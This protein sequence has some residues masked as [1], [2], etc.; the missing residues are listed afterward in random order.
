VQD[1][2]LVNVGKIKESSEGMQHCPALLFSEAM[3]SLRE[4]LARVLRF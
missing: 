2:R 3:I 4:S 1:F